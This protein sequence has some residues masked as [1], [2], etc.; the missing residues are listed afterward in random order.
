MFANL[1]IFGWIAAFLGCRPVDAAL[2]VSKVSLLMSKLSQ[3]LEELWSA[4]SLQE[5]LMNRGLSASD[6]RMLHF[7]CV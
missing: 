7:V 2:V 4:E 3:A 6:H 1:W 5:F